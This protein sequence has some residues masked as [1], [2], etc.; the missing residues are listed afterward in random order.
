MLALS[1][2]HRADLQALTG[3][4]SRDLS[5]IWREFNT[6]EAARD[7]LMD[8]LPRLMAIYGSAAA[9]LGADYY[10]TLRETAAVKGTFTAIP[11]ELPDL[12]RTEALARWGVSPLFKAEPDFA[13]SLT[14]VTGGMQRII[15]NADRQTVTLSAT[16]DRE[17]RGWQRVGSGHTCEFCAML[18]GRGA[19]YSEATADFESH[20]HCHCTA[21]P[22]FG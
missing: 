21:E 4:A 9:T 5:L 12:G 15:A 2:A 19:V 6:A 20:D 13:S 8:V 7:G 18:L 3:L 22:V 16:Q 1:K 17:S 10:D 11:A 14:L